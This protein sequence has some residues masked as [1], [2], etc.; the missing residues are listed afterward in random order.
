MW[1]PCIKMVIIIFYFFISL[2]IIY[3]F[4]YF[5]LFIYLFIY[6]WRKVFA[7]RKIVQFLG[8]ILSYYTVL[9]RN[10]LKL[11]VHLNSFL[12]EMNLK[13]CREL[14]FGCLRYYICFKPITK[15]ILLK[16]LFSINIRPAAQ[17]I[18]V[19]VVVVVVVWDILLVV[20]LAASSVFV[21]KS[22]PLASPFPIPEFWINWL[23]RIF[24]FY[25]FQHYHLV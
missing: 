4:I 22:P 24:I 10:A 8:A 12:T 3:L 20:C 19:A 6:F 16:G 25:L 5:Y 13:A 21:A 17:L 11:I 2:F 23:P 15:P 1:A 14:V 7:Q 9:L 18:D